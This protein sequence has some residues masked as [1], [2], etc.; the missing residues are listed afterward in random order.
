MKFS[1]RLVQKR[2]CHKNLF[3]LKKLSN[4]LYRVYRNNKCDH[5]CCFCIIYIPEQYE[6][7]FLRTINTGRFRI[8]QVTKYDILVFKAWKLKYYNEMYF[9]DETILVKESFMS[10]NTENKRKSPVQRLLK[11]KTRDVLYE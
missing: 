3:H 5:L 2:N 6:E 4:I 1:Y 7:H 8:H 11:G 9:S 10:S